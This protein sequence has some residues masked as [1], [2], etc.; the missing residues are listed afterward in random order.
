MDSRLRPAVI[1]A[2][3]YSSAAPAKRTRTSR[4]PSAPA[5]RRLCAGLKCPHQPS[6]PMAYP[7]KA[8]HMGGGGGGGGGAPPIPPMGAIGGGG[9]GGAPPIIAIG[10]GGGGGGIPPPI[11]PPIGA[12]GGGGGGGGGMPIP[13]MGIGG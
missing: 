6:W 11:P 3:W 4:A 8:F 1:V 2:P 5:A 9:G 13:P 7:Q 10:G 12:I